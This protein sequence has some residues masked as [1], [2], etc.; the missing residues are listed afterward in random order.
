MGADEFMSMGRM[1]ADENSRNTRICEPTF[2]RS[3][4]P[5]R[6][7]DENCIRYTEL[8]IP[9]GAPVTVLGR[10]VKNASGDLELMPPN[11][12]ELGKDPDDSDAERFRFR[13]LQG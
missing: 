8:A 1:A 13:I 6:R 10:P 12:A 5:R 2:L 4:L 11:S 7:D 9:R 3:D